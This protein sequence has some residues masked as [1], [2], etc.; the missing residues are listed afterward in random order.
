MKRLMTFAL[1][2]L[3]SLGVASVSLAQGKCEPTSSCGSHRHC[4]PNSPDYCCP[5][6]A[7]CV[8]T[9]GG[10]EWTKK[11]KRKHKQAPMKSDVKQTPAVPR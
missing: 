9:P 11:A 4:C 8:D 2:A 5:K 3:L 1:V 7:R 10:C 6:G